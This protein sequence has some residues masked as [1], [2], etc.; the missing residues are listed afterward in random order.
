M[1]PNRGLELCWH[2][3][4]RREARSQVVEVFFPVVTHFKLL[5]REKEAIVEP[6]M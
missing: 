5:D 4:T 2:R 6:A 1:G 3:E